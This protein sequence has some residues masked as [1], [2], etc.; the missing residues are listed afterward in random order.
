MAT[1]N[2]SK[3]QDQN[4]SDGCGANAR[5]LQPNPTEPNS[6]I[7][8]TK[9][10]GAK[11]ALGLVGFG[12]ALPSEQGAEAATISIPSSAQ[13]ERENTQD[14]PAVESGSTLRGGELERLGTL[15]NPVTPA[16]SNDFFG[17]IPPFDIPTDG[18]RGSSGASSGP[19][20]NP[21]G[22]LE[23]IMTQDELGGEFLNLDP[24]NEMTREWIASLQKEEPVP[25]LYTTLK[26]LLT[27]YAVAWS[28]RKLIAIFQ[29]EE[30]SGSKIK[31][32][33]P[34]QINPYA[35]PTSLA[36]LEKPEE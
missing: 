22:S 30:E 2:V 24:R 10:A 28:L 25:D 33:E 7:E 20:Y 3:N 5:N 6:W 8:W 13:A 29:K 27:A 32:D 23:G 36:Y 18:M 31:F 35:P 15:Q 21:D 4:H 19:V 14:S 9:T 16:Q 26:L 11:L 17:P 12:A 1:L 34:E